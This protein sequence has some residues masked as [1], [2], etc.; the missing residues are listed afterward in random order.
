MLDRYFAKRRLIVAIHNFHQTRD[1]LLTFTSS[2]QESQFFRWTIERIQVMV[3][4][5]LRKFAGVYRTERRMEKKRAE[6]EARRAAKELA[7]QVG[8]TGLVV[9]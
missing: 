9:Q 1:S 8:R 7:R 2:F 4:Q 5:F 3:D 6:E